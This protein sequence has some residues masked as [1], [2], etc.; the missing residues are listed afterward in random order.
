MMSI[1]ISQTLPKHF[2]G[3]QTLTHGCVRVMANQQEVG[4]SDQYC[5]EDQRLFSNSINKAT[6]NNVMDSS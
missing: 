4:L 2:P 3:V 1:V 5:L 6:H